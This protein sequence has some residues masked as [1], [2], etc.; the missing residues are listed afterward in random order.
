[1]LGLPVRVC[2]FWINS[3]SNFDGDEFCKNVWTWRFSHCRSYGERVALPQVKKFRIFDQA[4]LIPS[5]CFCSW[6]SVPLSFIHSSIKKTKDSS[7]ILVV[8]QPSAPSARYIGKSL[9]IF[10]KSLIFFISFF[11]S[12]RLKTDSNAV[13]KS[14]RGNFRWNQDMLNST[15]IRL[16]Q[17][18]PKCL[19]RRRQS[20]WIASVHETE[21]IEDRMQ[22]GNILRCIDT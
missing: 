4:L 10:K 11:R 18:R 2:K 5:F 8:S 16:C 7:Y 6:I 9:V 19:W 1:M 17:Y 3:D 13:L 21:E 12:S 15:V 22:H 20:L 14:G